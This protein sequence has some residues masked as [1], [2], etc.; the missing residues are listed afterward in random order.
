[1]MLNVTGRGVDIVH[2][3]GWNSLWNMLLQRPNTYFGAFV[4]VVYRPDL[5][6]KK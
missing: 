3:D 5:G 6:Y 1:M 2:H 4:K